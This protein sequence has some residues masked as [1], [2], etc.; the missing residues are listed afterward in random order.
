MILI[1]IVCFTRGPVGSPLCEFTKSRAH[2][3]SQWHHENDLAVVQD[4][5]AVDLNFLAAFP[6]DY[7]NNYWAP[8]SPFLTKLLH[9][10]Y[11]SMNVTNMDSRMLNFEEFRST[12]VEALN[13]LS[14]IPEVPH[15]YAAFG[16]YKPSGGNQKRTRTE[17]VVPHPNTRQRTRFSQVEAFQPLQAAD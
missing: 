17:S 1:H 15:K 12:L 3:I 4:L 13:H 14:K 6:E 9:I 11:P 7:V 16:P 8:F 5:K 10:V 2:R